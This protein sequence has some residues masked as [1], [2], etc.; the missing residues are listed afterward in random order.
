MMSRRPDPRALWLTAV[1]LLLGAILVLRSG[2][3]RGQLGAEPVG[4]TRALKSAGAPQQHDL[5]VFD[6]R[7]VAKPFPFN[8]LC[9]APN[10]P[11]G[12]CG[13]NPPATAACRGYVDA[14]GRLHLPG[15]IAAEP[16]QSSP[17][18]LILTEALATGGQS[19]TVQPPVGGCMSSDRTI[20]LAANGCRWPGSEVDGAVPLATA[21]AADGANCAAGNYAIGTDATGVAQCST[22]VLDA[23]ARVTVSRNGTVVGTRRAIN[24]IEGANVTLGAAD[25]AGN[26]RVDVTVTSTGAGAGISSDWIAPWGSR[27]GDTSVLT[28]AANT[29]HCRLVALPAS[30]P[31]LGA[32]TY[33]ATTTAAGSANLAVYTKS[34]ATRVFA[35]AATLDTPGLRTCYNTVALAAVAAGEYWICASGAAGQQVGGIKFPRAGVFDDGEAGCANGAMPATLASPATTWGADALGLELVLSVETTTSTTSTT[36]STTTTTLTASRASDTFA[37]ADNN[38]IGA[39]CS[40]CSWTQL[41]APLDGG[42]NLRIAS[43]RLGIRD[44]TA[45]AHALFGAITPSTSPQYSC[46]QYAV[47]SEGNREFRACVGITNGTGNAQDMVCCGF[48]IGSGW[49]MTAI[50]N[51]GTE[52]TV[53]SGTA[54]ITTGDW[55]GAERQSDTTFRCFQSSNGYTWSALGTGATT[56]SNIDVPGQPGVGLLGNQYDTNPPYSD[57]FEAGTGNLL[58]GTWGDTTA[59]GGHNVLR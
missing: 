26:E 52:S 8:G 36:T 15:G 21:L 34:G 17:S 32:I 44:A 13:N 45:T 42:A 31:R 23:A 57:N 16:Q 43:N 11:W 5:M 59:C 14:Q 46:T 54:T 55:I 48:K 29:C 53:D 20:T 27:G 2:P 47:T 38:D 25:N 12:C 22:G 49:Q 58:S 28:L 4:G 35:C 7:D 39:G 10:T 30:L 1:G 3:A 33:R 56:V 18:Q 9:T 24:L 41:T 37:S 6:R 51:G 40:S 19:L 50:A